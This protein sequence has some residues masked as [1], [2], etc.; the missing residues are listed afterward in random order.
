ME[1]FI[2][3][4]G[5]LG[6]I[7]PHEVSHVIVSI[8]S[9]VDDQARLPINAHTA[10]ILRLSFVDRDAPDPAHPDDR[11]FEIEDARAIWSLLRSHPDVSRLVVHCDA[12]LCRS[13]AVGAA[14]AKALTGDDE[15]YFRRY[16][17]NLRVYRKLLEAFHEGGEA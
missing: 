5:A 13:P 1:I 16:R 2:Y 3:S 4:R 10:G 7:T 6:M 12:G 14:V 17:P 9:H 8:T 11:L 15:A